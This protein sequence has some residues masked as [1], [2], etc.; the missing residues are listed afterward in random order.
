MSKTVTTT[1]EPFDPAILHYV[2][3]TSPQDRTTY[4][5]KCHCGAIRYSVTLK[6]PFPKYPVN[7]CT[8]SICTQNGYLLVYPMKQDVVFTQG[9]QFSDAVSELQTP[10]VLREA[11]GRLLI[12]TTLGYENLAQYKFNRQKVVHKF[13]KSCGSSILIDFRNAEQGETDPRKEILGINYPAQFLHREHQ[14]SN[15]VLV[16]S[17][18]VVNTYELSYAPVDPARIPPTFNIKPNKPGGKLYSFHNRPMGP[19]NV[20]E[21]ERARTRVFKD[22]M[23]HV[24]CAL[25]VQEEFLFD[26]TAQRPSWGV[27][28][29]YKQDVCLGIALKPIIVLLRDDLND[30]ERL[31]TQFFLAETI[32]HEMMHAIEECTYMVPRKSKIT[33]LEPYYEDEIV[34]ELGSSMTT[35][36]FGGRALPFFNGMNNQTPFYAFWFSTNWSNHLESIEGRSVNPILTSPSIVLEGFHY[37][38]LV[39]FFENIFQDDF[40]KNGVDK[41]GLAL[42]KDNYCHSGIRRTYKLRN[43]SADPYNRRNYDLEKERDIGTQP[44]RAWKSKLKEIHQ[45][46]SITPDQKQAVLYGMALTKSAASGEVYSNA[47]MSIVDSLPA[48]T[49]MAKRYMTTKSNT[50]RLNHLHKLVQCLETAVKLHSTAVEENVNIGRL[51]QTSYQDRQANLLNWNQGTRTFI[52]KLE[53]QARAQKSAE[54]DMLAARL[55]SLF[56]VEMEVARM[57]LCDPDVKDSMKADDFVEPQLVAWA[58]EALAA[59]D[60]PK[61]QGLVDAILQSVTRTPFVHLCAT[62]MQGAVPEQWADASIRLSHIHRAKHGFKALSR[63]IPADSTWGKVVDKW[64]QASIILHGRIEH[65]VAGIEEQ[66]DWVFDFNSRFGINSGSCC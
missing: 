56:A 3:E 21:A 11:F 2:E 52:R 25:Y 43:P 48:I 45:L 37:P 38:M 51:Q 16:A 35:A 29:S 55:H 32:V 4:D 34:T 19:N 27:T 23:R 58:A 62:L 64:L 63:G 30:A 31:S 66:E 13:C 9:Q 8:C 50:D 60:R 49:G 42:V 53:L 65:N 17:N 5:A 26:G 61:F 46:M 1:F 20:A 22:M 47:S 54:Y 57:Q 10:E 33:Y 14:T 41:L 6:H 40:W 36:V 39:A 59:R 44:G 28:F 18:P 12:R 7:Q 15:G 24:R